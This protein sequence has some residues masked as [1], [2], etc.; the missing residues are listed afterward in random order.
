VQNSL[1][2]LFEGMARALHERVAPALEDPAALAQL[3][4]MVELLGNLATRVTWDPIHLGHVRGRARRVI[5]ALAT[6]GAPGLEPA[7]VVTAAPANDGRALHDEVASL[8]DALARGQMWLAETDEAPAAL[9][10]EVD[11]F[12]DWY[13]AEES[14]RLRSAS[15][16]RE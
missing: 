6:A 9:R 11:A 12:V 14:T 13:L 5:E 15:Y 1:E 2:R 3:R 8:L 10:E 4:A 16:G 7:V